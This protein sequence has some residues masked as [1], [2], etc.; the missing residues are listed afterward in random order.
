MALDHDLRAANDLP[1]TCPGLCACSA[2]MHTDVRGSIPQAW[3]DSLLARIDIKD[4]LCVPLP[5]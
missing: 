2:L 1:A 3:C 5:P 4:R